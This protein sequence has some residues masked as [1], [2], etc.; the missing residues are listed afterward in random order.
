MNYD[1]LKLEFINAYANYIF[2]KTGITVSNDFKRDHFNCCDI[3]EFK[4]NDF[5]LIQGS[6]KKESFFLIK[7]SAIG[8][9]VTE[10]AETIVQLYIF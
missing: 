5:L 2:E 8:T 9:L 10:E 6:N 4:K 7:G 3:K 1:S